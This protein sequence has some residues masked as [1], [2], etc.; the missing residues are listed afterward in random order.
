APAWA[1]E[2]YKLQFDKSYEPIV[3]GKRIFVGSMV[4]DKVTAYDT[5]SGVEIWRFYCDGPVRF[6]PVGW[7]DRIYFVS[8]DGCLYCL[9]AADG[10]L[11][12]RTRLGPSDKK[13]LGNG[14]LISIWPG[15]GGPVLFDGKIY[16]AAS[17]WPFMGVFIY[18][19]DAKTGEIVW[20]NS[21]SGSR[22]MAQQHNSDAFGGV[23]PQGYLAATEERLLIPSRTTPACYD[24]RTGEFIY[25][26]LSD[27]GMGK[28][29]GGYDVCIR[30]DLFFNNGIMYRL[31]DGEGIVTTSVQVV[32]EDEI[33]AFDKDGE[34]V[35]YVPREV[36]ESERKKGEPAIKARGLWQAEF[37]PAVEKVHIQA[38]ARLYGSNSRGAIVAVDIPNKGEKARISWTY[39][40][41]GKAW[42]MLAGDDKLFVVTEEGLLYCFGGEDAEAKW[43][44]RADKPALE[45]P[46]EYRLKARQILAEAGTREGYCLLLG[47][48][49][50]KPPGGKLLNAILGESELNVIA[51]EPDAEIVASMRREMDE[52]GLYGR[53]ISIFTGD[54]TSLQLPAYFASVI[55][56]EDVETGGLDENLKVFVEKSYQSLRPYGGIAWLGVDAER[57]QVVA[58]R[59][60]SF[61][62]PGSRIDKQAEAVAVRRAGALAG[63]G[64]WIGQY[65]DSANTVVSKDELKGPLGLLWF[66]DDSKFADVLPRHGHGPAEQVAG[67]RLFI[68]GIDSISARDVYTGRTLWK[69]EIE[70]PNTFGVYFDK[71]YIGDYMDLSYNQVHI[72]GA[73]TRGTNFVATKD[74]IYIIDGAKCRVLDAATGGEVGVFSLPEKDGE[75]AANWAYMGVY[76]E[77][78]L[79]G[80]D[81]VSYLEILKGNDKKLDSKAKFFDK[82]ASRRLV[83][84]NRHTGEVLWSVDAKAGFIHNCIAAGGGRIFCLDALPPYIRKV[85]AERDI[86]IQLQERLLALDVRDGTITWEHSENVFGSWLGYSEKNDILLQAYRKSRD[87]V[88]EP[89]DRM[90]T[91]RG[92]TGEVLW[93]K[94]VDYNGPCMLRDEIIITQ[95]TAYSLLTGEQIMREHPLT[96]EPVKWEYSRNYGCNTAVASRNLLTFRSAA[97]GYFDLA[98][99]G[100]TGNF[101]GF[102]SGC[103]SNLIVANGVLNAPEYTRTCTCSYQ[104]QTSLALAHMPEVE[105]WTFNPIARG[106]G[107]IRR[108]GVNFGAPGDRKAENGTLWL[109]YPSRGGSSPAVSLTTKPEEPK[110]FTR[111]SSRIEKGVLPWVEASG[112]KG[113]SNIS[114]KLTSSG[115]KKVESDEAGAEKRYTVRLHFAEPDGKAQG[116]RVFDISINGKTLLK[117]FDIAK[118]A[119]APNIGIVKEFTVVQASDTMHISL[120]PRKRRGEPVIC[121]IELIAE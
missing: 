111:H 84:M 62:L 91:H 13:I 94:A 53:R 34:L 40:I 61:D 44:N 35:G 120:K 4:G 18:A 100:G 28:H 105:T 17:I 26:R 64:D 22:Y 14:R 97:A 85:M 54:V 29:V 50:G 114:I 71:T 33:I 5:D 6:A 66:G 56:A 99:D 86:E 90:A 60:S 79:G 8:D 80:A 37:G 104:N 20:E 36:P 113:I 98:G 7:K 76:G 73:N 121:G 95:E 75:P 87:M 27:R 19:I 31:A 39:Q 58:E 116:R 11:I 10:K 23:A 52:A 48:G 41:E 45:A 38:G 92:E 15:R 70:D 108:V 117:K 115:K 103:T 72:P 110:W 43:H 109:D 49:E 82:Y 24:R 47:I 93:D 51:V 112:A 83:V 9:A 25:Y 78:L 55:I 16:C 118:E 21:A 89:G 101:G 46:Q 32:A 1:E 74:K 106:E 30:K 77:Y 69:T 81:F 68:E 65:A 59:I 3:M 63:S 2:Q 119:G 42:N 96:G 107:D 102:K 12:R 67:G 88:P 57:R